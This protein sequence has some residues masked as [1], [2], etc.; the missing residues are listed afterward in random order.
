M[1]MYAFVGLL[2]VCL[3]KAIYTQNLDFSIGK[4]WETVASAPNVNAT[5]L[6]S[7]LPRR[8]AHM[9]DGDA[10]SSMADLRFQHLHDSALFLDLGMWDPGA[11]ALVLL[12]CVCGTCLSYARLLL[13][14]HLSATSYAMFSVVALLPVRIWQ[15]LQRIG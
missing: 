9:S 5:Q 11:L 10:L 4:D 14:T 3:C 2:F 8:I 1:N 6:S 7:Y 15:V 13:L 12:S